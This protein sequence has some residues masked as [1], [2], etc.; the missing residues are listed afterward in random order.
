VNLF[1][2]LNPLRSLLRLEDKSRRLLQEL[3]T[4]L[5]EPGHLG[6]VGGLLVFTIKLTGGRVEFN[7]QFVELLLVVILVS[8]AAV[9]EPG[10]DVVGLLARE[11]AHVIDVPKPL[12]S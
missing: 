3:I 10:S 5:L 4:N 6:H 11:G 12:L 1:G 2:Q 8:F 9:I 7:L